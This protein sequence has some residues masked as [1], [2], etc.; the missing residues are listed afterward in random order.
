[1]PAHTAEYLMGVGELDPSGDRWRRGRK[2][3]SLVLHVF[4]LL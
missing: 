1:M 4:P 2:L 3:R